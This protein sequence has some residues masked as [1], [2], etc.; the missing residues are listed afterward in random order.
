MHETLQFR[1]VQIHHH[2]FPLRLY[3]LDHGNPL[4]DGPIHPHALHPLNGLYFRD[5]QQAENSRESFRKQAL[6]HFRYAAFIEDNG[7]VTNSPN[8]R[9]RL[10]NEMLSLIKSFGGTRWTQKLE[11]FKKGHGALKNLY[12]SKRNMRKMPTKINGKDFTFSPGKH[13]Q[14]QKA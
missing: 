1:Q 9:Y 3:V 11:R 12:A 4:Q 10:T 5:R 7:K 6:H 2:A 13:N 14:L 8:Y